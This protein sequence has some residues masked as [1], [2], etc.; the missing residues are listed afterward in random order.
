MIVQAAEAQGVPLNIALGVASHESRFQPTAQNPTS[1][2]AGLFQLISATQQTMGVT[3]PYDPQQNTNAAMSLLSTYYARYGSWNLALQAFSDGPG[4]VNAGSPPSQQ[5]RDL[6]GYISTFDSNS[7][8]ASL[9]LVDTGST[10]ADAVA[11]VSDQASA[12][13]AGIDFTDPT[14]LVIGLGILAGVVWIAREL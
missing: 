7:I 3:N 13:V 14:T 11:G 9:G 12:L 6:I 5:T 4:T 8:L 10:V 2:A 1:S